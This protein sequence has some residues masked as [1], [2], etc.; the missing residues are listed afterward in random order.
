MSGYDNNLQSLLT[1]MQDYGDAVKAKAGVATLPSLRIELGNSAQANGGRGIDKGPYYQLDFNIGVEVKGGLAPTFETDGT[2]YLPAGTYA[3]MGGGKIISSPSQQTYDLP[4]QLTL[5]TGVAYG[6]P[7]VY[8]NAVQSF[9]DG[10]ITVGGVG[11][12]G[13]IATS[14]M[15]T[16]T[17]TLEAG[18]SWPVWLG[19]SKV[20]SKSDTNT[21]LALQGYVEYLK[22]Q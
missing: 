10:I 22:I 7:G 2:M 9:P 16:L 12:S 19:F 15:A 21:F 18:L 8:Q 14:G 11:A 6:F 5:A 3:V 1:A 17:G 4:P 13:T 20:Q